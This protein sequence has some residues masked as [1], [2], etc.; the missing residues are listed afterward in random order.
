[1]ALMAASVLDD[2]RPGTKAINTVIVT[3]IRV[4]AFADRFRDVARIDAD[5]PRD[6]NLDLGLLKLRDAF[7]QLA[8]GHCHA[9]ALSN[10][11][12]PG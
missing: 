12:R 2:E 4:A 3:S 9:A 7:L 5:Q 6:T 1:M 11:F 8:I 10:I